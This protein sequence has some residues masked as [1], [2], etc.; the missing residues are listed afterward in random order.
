MD[1]NHAI[2]KCPPTPLIC[3]AQS[4][5]VPSQS[6]AQSDLLIGRDFFHMHILTYINT[7]QH[8]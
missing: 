6:K 1:W 7:V 8:F 3:E 4:C 5:P 2:S